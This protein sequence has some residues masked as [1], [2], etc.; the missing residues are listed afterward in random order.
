MKNK[1]CYLFTMNYVEKIPFDPDQH[2][3]CGIHTGL[4]FS[5]VLLKSSIKI[6]NHRIYIKH[7]DYGLMIH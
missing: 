1:N 6:I 5:M 4:L 7:E 3:I 2:E